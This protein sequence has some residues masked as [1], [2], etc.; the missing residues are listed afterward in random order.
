MLLD[1]KDQQVLRADPDFTVIYSRR[2]HGMFQIAVYGKGGIG[3]STISANLSVALSDRGKKVMQIGCDPKHDSTRLLLGGRTQTTVLDYVRAVPVGKRRL[4]DVVQEGARGVLCTEAGGPEPGIGCA[5]RGI[6]TTFDVLG[7]LGMDTLDTDVRIYD[8]LGDVV[9]GGFAVPLRSEYADAVVIVTSGEFMAMYA[10]NNIMRGMRNFDT[11]SPRLLGVVLN[12]RGVEGEEEL[13]RRF[14]EAAGTEVIATIP[15]DRAF[16]E[17]ESMGHTVA[18]LFPESSAAVAMGAVADRVVSVIEGKAELYD[19]RP[20]DDDQLSDLAAGREIRQG[21]WEPRMRTGCGACTKRTSIRDCRVMSSC[22]AYG[23][24]AAYRKLDDVA[25]VIHGPMS[26]AYLMETTRAKAVLSL[27]EEGVYKG[28]PRCNVFSTRMDDSASIFGGNAFLEWSLGDAASKGYR[29]V[30]V[31]TTCMP[32]IIGDDCLSVVDRF[33]REHPDVDVQLVTADGDIAGDYNDGFMLAAETMT[34]MMDTGVERDDGLVNLVGTSFFDINS[35]A[36]MLDLGNMLSAFGLEVNCRFL[37]E[38]TS[39]SVEGFC[40]AGTDIL[41]SPSAFNRSLMS[42]VTRRTGRVPFDL[43]L[44]VGLEEYRGWM[45]AMGGRLGMEDMARE[46]VAAA[47]ASYDAF[48]GSDRNRLD[49]VR[50]MVASK[51]GG[52]LGWLLDLLLDLGADVL[53]AAQFGRAGGKSPGH[54]EIV[55]DYQVESVGPDLERLRPDLLVSD[56]VFSTPEGTR[57]AKLSKAGVGYGQTLR[58]ARYLSDSMRLPETD[59]WRFSA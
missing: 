56:V 19:P 52:N 29:K 7:K 48:V 46:A 40:R 59:G 50:V 17:A 32:G 58:Y 54:P 15:R 28:A 23:A 3:K 55:Q 30:A 31:V 1:D 47:D 6:L 13:V 20:L 44:P 22:A 37:D 2:K 12:S 51:M 10:A 41:V 36:N 43:P 9:C 49:G 33:G 34:F 5:G 8:V 27:Y 18:E 14:A 16:A 21:G 38:T 39:S 45:A 53:L 4:E 42:A 25:V 35:R 11:G 24:V 26:C 57:F